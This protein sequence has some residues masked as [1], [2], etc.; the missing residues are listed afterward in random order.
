VFNYTDNFLLAHKLDIRL[1]L[2]LPPF[3]LAEGKKL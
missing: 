2:L 3:G 1:I